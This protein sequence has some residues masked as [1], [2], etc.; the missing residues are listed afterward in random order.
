M[1]WGSRRGHPGG[2]GSG[3]LALSQQWA[4]PGPTNPTGST[5]V[6]GRLAAAAPLL[7]NSRTRHMRALTSPGG[8]GFEVSSHFSF[9]FTRTHAQPHRRSSTTTTTTTTTISPNLHSLPS[10]LPRPPEY[11]P[12]SS[13][14]IPP[15]FRSTDKPPLTLI[16]ENT[17]DLFPLPI[18]DLHSDP[19]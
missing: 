7:H 13:P 16:L 14:T 18:P 1:T 17:L 3:G 19:R 12:L 4:A 6:A 9:H 15:T 11:Q 5:G 2:K 8:P 10:S